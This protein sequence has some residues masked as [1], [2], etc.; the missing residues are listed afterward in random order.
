MGIGAIGYNTEY[1]RA[2]AS[3]GRRGAVDGNS[4]FL[5]VGSYSDLF[6]EAVQN[7]Y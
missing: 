6:S 2:N 7:F 1:Y 4:N 3:L 5:T